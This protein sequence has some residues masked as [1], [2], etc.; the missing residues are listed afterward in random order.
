MTK[1]LTYEDV[2]E[3]LTEIINNDKI[4]KKDLILIYQLGSNNHLKLQEHVHHINKTNGEFKPT[5]SF[6]INVDDL[7]VKFIKKNE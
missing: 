4:I 7:T 6:E 1:I 5:E 3:T 2:I